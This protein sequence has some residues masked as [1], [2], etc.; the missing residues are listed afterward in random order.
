MPGDSF[1]QTELLRGLV[2]NISAMVAYW[3]SSQ[4]CRLAN[5]AYRHWFGVSPETLLGTHIRDLL[6]PRLYELNLPYIEGA[7]RG[8]RQEF[9]RDIPTPDG[10]TR[11]SLASYIP[12][13]VD[14]VVRGFFVLVTD[15]S[16]I[17]QAERALAKSEERFRLTFDEAPIGMALVAPDGR[18]IRVNRALCDIVG[19]A[20]EELTGLAFQAITHPDD[21]DADLVLAGQLARG[22][23]PRY[24]RGK[25][26]I[27]KDGAIVDIMLSGSVV[28][29]SAG[30]PLYFIAQIEDITERKRLEDKLRLAEA[31]SSGILAISAD[32]I[33]SI[34]EHHRI[35]M[36]NEGA[37]QLFGYTAAETIGAPLDMLIPERFREVHRQH[38]GRF[39]AEPHV[40]RGMGE[41]GA[42]IFGRRK[43][44]QEFPADASISRLRVGE[45]P[46][47][48]VAL[49][50]I[51][52]QKR[53]EHEQR[54]L[55]DVGEVLASTLDYK[56]TL[57]AVAELAA[58]DL[59]DLCI[60]DIVEQGDDEDDAKTLHVASK[61][62][63]LQWL[64]E[65]HTLDAGEMH[66][67]L[68]VPLLTHGRVMG[69]ITFV[70]TTP[71][72]IY[73]P[74]D[75]RLAE[76]LARRAALSIE[77]AKLYL[78]AQR[79][80]QVR[81]EVLG[82]VAHDLRNPLNSMML[83]AE[84]VRLDAM[85]LKPR[86]QN[87]IAAM[88]RSARRMNRLIED[89]LEVTRIEA[90]RLSVVLERV[91]ARDLLDETREAQQRLADTA[92]IK[93]RVEAAASL[94]DVLG[95]RDRLL[96]A[97]DNLI[98]NALKFTEPGGTITV[99][100]V[101]HDG[102]VLFSVTDTGSGIPPESLPHV[103]DRFWQANKGE[104]RGAGLGLPIV[105]GVIEA[106]HGRISVESTPGAGSTFSFTI[107]MADE[108]AARPLPP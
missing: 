106:H 27:R 93:L 98:G 48:T 82:I 65:Q 92:A 108:A 12:D 43:N 11:S 60:V 101:P 104:R 47:L 30:A 1:H 8:E 41:R 80:T 49:R 74:A 87:A 17:K 81:D 69:A 26:Y 10:G 36:F 76:E 28:R 34:D 58:R 6:G 37:E 91:S 71:S 63:E 59:A 23:I 38:V 16:P 5:Q 14:G 22:E 75:V 107:P 50:D 105:K 96:Q 78:D 100:A 94:P 95:D 29:D 64:S 70:S 24:Q 90:G 44:G 39:A 68:E 56:Q 20:A 51:T 19:Y 62:P 42:P 79:A 18:F 21:L 13:V 67:V 52:E 7:L 61:D 66:S 53:V 88:E 9:E 25:R 33:I 86:T 32:A 83:N 102:A 55:A 4:R 97:L 72:R 99:R 89:L 84:L 85:E 40:S 35:T 46:V 15:V 3:D 54:F 2:D 57:K 103:F 73:G 77:N 45:I 31:R